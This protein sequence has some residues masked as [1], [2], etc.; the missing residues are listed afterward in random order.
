M[1]DELICYVS[2]GFSPAHANCA[3]PQR[4]TSLDEIPE[5]IKKVLGAV[6][7]GE[8]NTFIIELKEAS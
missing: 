5:Y 7:L 6:K 4:L 3:K 2:F 8:A 1:T